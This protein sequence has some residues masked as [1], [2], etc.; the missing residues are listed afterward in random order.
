[1][2]RPVGMRR[3]SALESRLSPVFTRR[4]AV[5]LSQRAVIKGGHKPND[6]PAHG[7]VGSRRAHKKKGKAPTVS[8]L[9]APPRI[10]SDGI[11]PNLMIHKCADSPSE[12][13]PAL[14]RS[15]PTVNEMVEKFNDR[16]KEMDL[17]LDLSGLSELEIKSSDVAPA[18]VLPLSTVEE[19]EARATVDDG[20]PLDTT[21][22][23]LVGILH[24]SRMKQG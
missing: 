16:V 2:R 13:P 5:W 24:S 14:A 12:K 18:R 17:G 10:N 22:G 21:V 23:W 9:I 15:S 1:M 4:S 7:S 6:T 8:I 11:P 19:H 20:H 3:V